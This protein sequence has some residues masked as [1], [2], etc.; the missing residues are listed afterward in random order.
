MDPDSK[1]D[2][3]IFDI[4]WQ[5]VLCRHVLSHLN[6]PTLFS[7][8]LV[9][10][11]FCSL[12]D[13]HFSLVFTINTSTYADCFSSAAFTVL[14][15]RNS[16][17]KKMILCNSKDW[18]SDV[19]LLPV[20]QNNPLLD[21]IDLANCLSISNASLYTIG[22]YC[23]KLRWLSLRGCVWVTSD[24][25]LPLIA[26]Q[27]PLEYVDLSGCWNLDDEAIIQLVQYCNG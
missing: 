23:H 19:S 27:Q 20:I 3:S 14:T 15:S 26:N 16:F 6:L 9:S 2:V 18:L 24:G 4:P 17:L 11:K 5:E 10:Q 22:A 21:T 7:L 1:S 25:M 8:R 13:L 12:V